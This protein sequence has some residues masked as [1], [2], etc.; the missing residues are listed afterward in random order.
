MNSPAALKT[1]TQNCM[2]QEKWS[3]DNFRRI[4]LLCKDDMFRNYDSLD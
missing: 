3:S 1:T 2:L 4:Y